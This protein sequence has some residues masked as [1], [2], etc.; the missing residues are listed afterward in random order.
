[1]VYGLLQGFYLLGIGSMKVLKLRLIG[2]FKSGQFL[3]GGVYLRFK[4]DF[5]GG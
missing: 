3:E 2:R 1:M 5:L 4:Q